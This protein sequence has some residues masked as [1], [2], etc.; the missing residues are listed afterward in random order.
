M[1]SVTLITDL[2]QASHVHLKQRKKF[3]EKDEPAFRLAALFPFDG[4]RTIPKLGVTYQSSPN[5]IV[6]A[7]QEVVRDEWGWEYDP[8]NQ[9][10]SKANGVQFP[11]NFAN[12]NLVFKKDANGNPIPNEIDPITKDKIIL[13]LKNTMDVPC[14]NGATN[15]IQIID[16]AACYS[17]CVGRAQL[18]VSA[19]TTKGDTPSKILSIRLIK[20]LMCYDD[21]PF[22]NDGPRDT[23]EDAFAAYGVTDSNLSVTT[24]NTEFRPESQQSPAANSPPAMKKPPAANTPHATKKPPAMKKPPAIKKEVTGTVIMN[25]DCEYTYASL[26]EAGYTDQDM[27][28]HG[29]A[30]PNFA[31]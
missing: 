18:E 25:E 19:F 13:N 29:Y 2:F 27:I 9:E 8:Y 4:Q 14:A 24:G 11:P 20:F 10:F 28:D 26:I 12:G 17:G 6:A 31:G 21:E 30:V 22:G 16:P 23:V 15:P 1:S 7:L 3:N 5:N